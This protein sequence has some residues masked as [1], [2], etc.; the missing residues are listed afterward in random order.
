MDTDFA[1]S[2]GLGEDALAR[3]MSDIGFARSE[4]T[5]RWRGRHASR[6]QPRERASNAFAELAKLK[7]K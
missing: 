5:W 4:G 6:R 2:I 7:N 1:T 3:L